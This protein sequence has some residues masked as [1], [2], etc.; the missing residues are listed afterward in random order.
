MTTYYPRSRTGASNFISSSGGTIDGDLGITGL[1]T[2]G[3]L[4][5]NGNAII[6]GNLTVTGTFASTVTGPQGATG[7]AATVALG[8]VNT[9]APGTSVII[10]NSGPDSSDAIFNF[11]IP[12]GAQGIQGSTGNAG[13]A[14]SI[15]VGSTNTLSAGSA[16]TVTNSGSSS[17]AVLVFGIPQGATGATGST[18]ASGA[19]ATLAVGAVNTLSPGTSATVTNSGTGSAAVF[20]FGIPQGATG[21]TGAS[22]AA[23]TLAVGAVNTLSVG[24]SATVTNSGSSSAAVFNFGIPT[25]ATGASGPTGST[26][27]TGSAATIGVGTVN[28][29]SAGSSATVTNSGTTSAAVFNFGIP[30][31]ATGA[32]GSTGATPSVSVG[33][34]TTGAAGTSVSVTNTGTSPNVVL[35]F[36]IP[37]GATGSTGP[38]GATGST[39]STGST[40]TA[41]TIA[42]GT[43]TTLGAGSSATVTNSGSSS[44]AVFNFGVP[45]GP[46]GATGAT[47]A[48]GTFNNTSSINTTGNIQGANITATSVLAASSASISGT[49]TFTSPATTNQNVLNVYAPNMGTFNAVAMA[50]GLDG[51]NN[52]DR[53]GLL[54]INNGGT[55]SSTNS[56]VIGIGSA[57]L[58][59]LGSGK[60][61]TQSGTVLDDSNGNMV[62]NGNAI[63]AFEVNSTATAA[64]SS[65]FFAPN[66]GTNGFSQLMF[67]A[68]N[69][70]NAAGCVAFVNAAGAPSATN[71]VSLG[72]QNSSKFLFVNGNGKIYSNNSVFD[73]GTGAPIF[74]GP[75]TVTSNT[76]VNSSGNNIMLP[77][78][79][80]TVALTSQL[81]TSYLAYGSINGVGSSPSI[82][83]INSSGGFTASS[84]TLTFPS[85]GPTNWEIKWNMTGALGANSIGSVQLTLGTTNSNNTSIVA[86]SAT[87][88][89][90]T[91]MSCNGLAIINNPGTMSFVTSGYAS[92]GYGA[93]FVVRGLI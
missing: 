26:G 33:T 85:G 1:F 43:V 38:T 67:G 2:S 28:T 88:T 30:A 16:A 39:G 32:T 65:Q 4:D 3:G 48:T 45:T 87:S 31:G 15:A 7:K 64:L 5:V 93:S 25:G 84:T 22:G 37:Q 35:N 86:S 78:G 23:A 89:S 70:T 21:S 51:N 80:G 6:N 18:G 24:S 81:P 53:L 49:G 57:A 42:V 50:V 72:L 79:P 56:A 34:V 41:A 62:I 75:V 90:G 40:G 12:V 19:A 74:L 9:G 47:G 46:Q 60:I 58:T 44:A 69:A 71:Y 76:L 14:A 77:T 36:T 54:F 68:S 13:A 17:A 55:G 59:L 61:S 11:T 29:L 8:N 83:L 66:I 73:D 82:T 63:V 52:N 27:A 92:V 91:D 10:T 20:N